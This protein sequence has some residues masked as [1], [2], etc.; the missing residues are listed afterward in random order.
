MHTTEY[1]DTY[2]LE[3]ITKSDISDLRDILKVVDEVIHED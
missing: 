3:C 1:E 2:F